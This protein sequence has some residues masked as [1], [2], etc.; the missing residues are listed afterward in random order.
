MLWVGKM[1]EAPSADLIEPG[2]ITRFARNPA[3]DIG[4][5]DR[6]AVRPPKLHIVPILLHWL[7]V[8]ISK[9]KQ[10]SVLRIPTA[11]PHRIED[12]KPEFPQSLIFAKLTF[13]EDE[14]SAFDRVARIELPTVEV[15]EDLSMGSD[16]F[17]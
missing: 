14:P 17:H 4:G 8:H 5:D 10:S 7:V 2:L 12:R 11:S 13:V 1:V 6:F 16:D 9:V 3:S 15:I